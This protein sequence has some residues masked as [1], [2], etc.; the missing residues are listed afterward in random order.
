MLCLAAICGTD[1]LHSIL[2]GTF[3]ADLGA[4]DPAAERPRVIWC[5]WRTITAGLASA[6]NATKH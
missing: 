1:G 3:G 5:S 6:G 4:A 2:T